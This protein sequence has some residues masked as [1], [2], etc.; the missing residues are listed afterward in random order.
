MRVSL[1]LMLGLIVVAGCHT[2]PVACDARL[3]PINLPAPKDAPAAAAHAPLN[4]GAKVD[5]VA[6]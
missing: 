6:P 5:R 2:A 3:R 4:V 1:L